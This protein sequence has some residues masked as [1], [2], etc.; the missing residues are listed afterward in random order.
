MQAGRANN[1]AAQSILK[2]EY[3]KDLD[4]DRVLVKVLRKT[5]DSTSLNTENR[6][7]IHE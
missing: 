6:T 5:M 7:W 1:S 4:T 2:Q 3:T